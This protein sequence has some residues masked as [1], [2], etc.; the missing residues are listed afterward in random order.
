VDQAAKL[1]DPEHD[2]EQ[3]WQGQHELHQ[4]L[5]EGLRA[6]TADEAGH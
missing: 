2:E 6:E 1:D 5:A 3:D 4:G